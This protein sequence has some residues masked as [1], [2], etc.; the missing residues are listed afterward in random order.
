MVDYRAEDT[1]SIEVAV[2]D[3]IE[4]E[5]LR[6]AVVPPNLMLVPFWDAPDIVELEGERSLDEDGVHGSTAVL[7]A[8]KP[9]SG[10]LLLGFRDLQTNK[11]VR[12]KRIHVEVTSE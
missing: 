6:E 3:R 5:S 12:N 2:G 11:I 1:D 9:G 7:H 4:L 8:M 10:E